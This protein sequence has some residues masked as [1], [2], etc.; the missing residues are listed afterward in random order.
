MSARIEDVLI[1]LSKDP[2]RAAQFLQNPQTE[3]ELTPDEIGVLIGDS[4][5]LD[6]VLQITMAKNDGG[7]AKPKTKPKPKKKAT[8]K[9]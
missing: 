4:D 3:T 1:E 8:K 2:F 6:R 5:R 7:P 9:K